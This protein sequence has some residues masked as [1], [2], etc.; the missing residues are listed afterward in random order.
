MAIV[1]ADIAAHKKNVRNMRLRKSI[2]TAI[3][4][5][6][7]PANGQPNKAA[8]AIKNTANGYFCVH[9]AAKAEQPKYIAKEEG[10]KAVLDI[11]MP[12]LKS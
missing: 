4:R 12:T 6:I 8:I 9:Q 1:A 2:S 7:K 11:N 3:G 10:N 5:P